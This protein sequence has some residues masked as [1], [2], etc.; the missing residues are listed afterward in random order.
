MTRMFRLALTT[1]AIFILATVPTIALVQHD[2]ILLESAV[3]APFRHSFVGTM[4]N[5]TW[6]DGSPESRVIKTFHGWPDRNRWEYLDSEGNPAFI[7]INNGGKQWEI[8]LADRTVYVNDDGVGCCQLEEVPAELTRLFHNYRAICNGSAVIAGRET[9][10]FALHPLHAGNPIT[11]LW[12]DVDTGIVLRLE[13]YS[14][15]GD[16][17]ELRSYTSFELVEELDPSLFIY[18]PSIRDKVVHIEHPQLP[19]QV[20]SLQKQLGER[21]RY[22]TSLPPG[23]QFSKGRVL[24]RFRPADT[25]QLQFADGLNSISV[26]QTFYPDTR[27]LRQGSPAM[28]ATKLLMDET[29]AFLV[30]AG[31]GYVLTWHKGNVT[32]SIVG[33]LAV[34][35]LKR[36]AHSFRY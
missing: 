26:F 2:Y 13:R 33:N 27:S 12:I 34:Q 14:P 18:S 5:I 8:S 1:I 9:S 31:E 30:Q 22:P 16:L 21:I 28:E 6:S 36:L 17:L 3:L 11:M 10:I 25:V 15:D 35:E 24:S 29:E 19:E 20:I 23:Y 4:L 7:I 32:Y